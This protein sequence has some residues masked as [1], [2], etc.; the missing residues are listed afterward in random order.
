VPVKVFFFAAVLLVSGCSKKA[1][2]PIIPPLHDV[3]KNGIISKA[4]SWSETGKVYRVTSDCSIEAPVTWGKGIVV[5]V[6]PAAVVR[7][8]N[9]GVLTIEE[10]VTVK[11]RDGAYIE[12][13]GQSPGT[14]I[15]NGSAS[16]PVELSADTG[17]QSWGLSS[18]SRS[19]GIVLGDSANNI[20]LSYCTIT[21]A[22]AGI[23][24]KAGSPYIAN[25]KISSCKG[26]GIYFDSAAGP[27]DS[28]TFTNNAISGC[29]GYP[30]TLPAGKLGNLSGEIDFSVPQGGKG[31]VHVLGAIIDDE[32]AVWRKMALP[33]IFNGMTMVSSST[34]GISL[35]TIMPGVVC[36]FEA[37]A[38]IKIGDPRFGS[39]T[40]IARG[41]PADSIFF[42]NSSPDTVWGD[43]SGGIWVG[44]ESPANTIL[45]YCS[46]QNATTGIFV[47]PGTRVTVSHCQVA[48]CA[49]NGITF[50]GGSP[51]DSQA[52]QGNFCV[53]N[54]GYGISITA[55]QLT[56]LSGIGSVAGNGKGGIYVTGAQVWQSGAWK[57]YDEPYIVDGVLDIG[58]SGGVEISI[59][60]GAEFDFLPGAYM[61]V[62]NSAQGT[63]IAIGTGNFP[64]VF[65][66]F[67]RGEYWGADTDSA[68]G[69][70]IRIEKNAGNGTELT[71]CT[72]K[73]ATSGV[74][75]NA[76][77][78]IQSCLFQDN[79]Y[80]G[81]ITGANAD[82]ALISGNSFSGNGK[83]S[84]YVAP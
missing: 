47:T 83:D 71:N 42:V 53:G 29:G 43:S 21:G 63:L 55:D 27:A 84:I 16:A 39:G 66:S 37:G 80:Y 54:A 64:I 1:N 13:G 19:G 28:A 3:T 57:K 31:A 5:A 65:T 38:C 23:Y 51:I 73:N 10:N 75:V 79:Q 50:A 74:Y 40:L 60:P 26:D 35:V 44:Q 58:N 2:N 24:V 20:R 62:G 70:G 41:T 68:S 9:N 52:F 17:A 78:K 18:G 25:C 36:K 30:L 77:A 82:P 34:G 49:L 4:E 15:A 46:I 7:I 81:L 48:G 76:D 33:Y 59:P 61:S 22:A 45:E 12:A 67:V 32:A 8:V 11:L 72:I 69:G 56:N 6:D 14:L